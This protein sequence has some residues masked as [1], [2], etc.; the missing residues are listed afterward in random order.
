MS[1]KIFVAIA[2]VGIMMGAGSA[3]AITWGTTNLIKNQPDCNL[4]INKNLPVCAVPPA[5]YV[6]AG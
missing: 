3:T 4:A 5:T 2:T 6:S 1:K